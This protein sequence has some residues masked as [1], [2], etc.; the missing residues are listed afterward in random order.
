MHSDEGIG[1]KEQFGVEKCCIICL[2]YKCAISTLL[3]ASNISDSSSNVHLTLNLMSLTLGSLYPS[4]MH[5]K[6]CT[7]MHMSACTRIPI[8][9]WF[10]TSL[11]IQSIMGPKAA[12]REEISR[13]LNNF[14]KQATT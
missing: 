6:A 9:L 12:T 2:R 7:S 3:S 13:D 4:H 11:A 14:L 1:G 5:G 10:W 8:I